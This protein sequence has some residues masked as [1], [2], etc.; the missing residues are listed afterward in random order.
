MATYDLT[1]AIPS[2]IVA[3]DILNIPYSG[4]AISITLQKGKYKLECWGAQGGY[5]SSSSYGGKGGKSTGTLTLTNA[6]N[7]Y[8]YTGG[9]GNTGKTNGGFNGGGKR[10]TYN[11]GGG[12]S[13][14]RIGSDSVYARVIVAGGGGSDGATSKGGGAGGGTTAQNTTASSYGTGGYAGTQTGNNGGSGWLVSSRPSG[15]SSQVNCYAGF[16]FGGNGVYSNNGYGGAGGGGWYGGTGTIPDSSG[17]DDKGGGG[18]SGYIYT[19]STASNYP[20]GCLLNSSMYL[21]SASTNSGTTS[22][23]SPTGASETGHSGD[24]YVRITVI[25]AQQPTR[26]YIK[27]NGVW[28]EHQTVKF[29]SKINGVWRVVA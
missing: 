20:S 16:G 8:I 12:A 6:S 11:G 23:T 13:D 18:G 22:F 21:D 24:G 2:K 28:K 10:A 9:A 17:D 7:I 1:S 19:S 5:R 15:T 26:F 27:A 14:V 29:Y 4:R 25:E 3:N